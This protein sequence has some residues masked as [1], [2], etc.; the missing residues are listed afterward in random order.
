M[1][2]PLT[3]IPLEL[4][5]ML[6]VTLGPLGELLEEEGHPWAGLVTRV[7]EQYLAGRD[8]TVFDNYLGEVGF[9]QIADTTRAAAERVCAL[10]DAAVI[11]AEHFLCWADEVG[12]ATA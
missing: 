9:E 8:Q 5:E 4:A 1:T 6:H 7:L 3:F 12:E 10:T 2:Q 11:E